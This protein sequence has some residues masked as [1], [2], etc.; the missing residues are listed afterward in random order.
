M[1]VAAAA[2]SSSATVA[3]AVMVAMVVEAGLLGG[4]VEQV[5]A[6]VFQPIH[7]GSRVSSDEELFIRTP[8]LYRLWNTKSYRHVKM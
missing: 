8:Q 5:P 1:V 2:A 3:V 7:F 6:R 4:L